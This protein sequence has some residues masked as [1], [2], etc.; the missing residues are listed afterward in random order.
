MLGEFEVCNF[1]QLAVCVSPEMKH[2]II[3]DRWCKY[4]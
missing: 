2:S 1:L 3:G 4:K